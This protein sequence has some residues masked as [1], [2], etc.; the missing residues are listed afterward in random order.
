MSHASGDGR[1]LSNS[2]KLPGVAPPPHLGHLATRGVPTL[3]A[4]SVLGHHTFPVLCTSQSHEG[5]GP[6]TR[7]EGPVTRQ[8][9]ASHTAG[10]GQSHGREGPVTRQG[11]A[12]HAG[13][14]SQSHEGEEPVTR[15]GGASHAAGRGQSRG[16]EGGASHTRGRSQSH[17][18][19]G[20]VT[21][22]DVHHLRVAYLSS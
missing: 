4:A 11:G 5:E 14:R 17:E 22:A 7:G 15:Q 12:S 18:G 9:G 16:R 2:G 1:T 20:P 19:E 6:V 13:G 8:G 10:R 21:S 3:L